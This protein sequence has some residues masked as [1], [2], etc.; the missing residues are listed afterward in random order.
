M[1]LDGLTLHICV[2]EL[3]KRCSDAK[4]QK[5]LMPGREEIVLQLYSARTSCWPAVPNPNATPLRP[6]SAATA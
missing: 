5:I 3:R 1:T 6:P 2:S 4:I